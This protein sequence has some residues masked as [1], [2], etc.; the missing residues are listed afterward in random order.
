MK[1]LNPHVL[2]DHLSEY[3]KFLQ[4]FVVFFLQETVKIIVVENFID[5]RLQWLS[6]VSCFH[7][8]EFSFFVNWK[9]FFAC[10]NVNIFRLDNK[11][12][13]EF[14]S[15]CRK[16]KHFQCHVV[17][18][19]WLHEVKVIPIQILSRCDNDCSRFS[20]ILF[21][22]VLPINYLCTWFRYFM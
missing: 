2:K 16:V 17:D 12:L 7:L 8:I 22:P 19:R 21:F 9:L 13:I 6:P 4:W 5:F 20:L 1:V 3:I 11:L 10:T 18:I 14:N 15:I